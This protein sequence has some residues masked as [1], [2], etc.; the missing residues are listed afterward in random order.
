MQPFPPHTSKAKNNIIWSLWH[1]NCRNSKKHTFKPKSHDFCWMT[2][3]VVWSAWLSRNH[4]VWYWLCVLY[5]LYVTEHFVCSILFCCRLMYKHWAGLI[6]VESR[7]HVPTACPTN[8]LCVIACAGWWC[9]GEIV[10]MFV[11]CTCFSCDISC[12][13]VWSSCICRHNHKHDLKMLAPHQVYPALYSWLDLHFNVLVFDKQH[14]YK[15]THI[16]WTLTK[17]KKTVY[18]KQE[19]KL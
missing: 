16:I 6:L 12:T 8:W 9:G 10:D 7:M 4:V 15:T 18:I 11:L 1:W 3:I 17:N 2:M 13:D 19:H 5:T 14:E